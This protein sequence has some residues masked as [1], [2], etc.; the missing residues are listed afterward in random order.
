MMTMLTGT[1]VYVAQLDSIAGWFSLVD[2]LMFNDIL[3]HQL[4]PTYVGAHGDLLEIGCF[5]GKS[6]ILLGYGRG[7][8]SLVVCDIFGDPDL[9][10]CAD[11]HPMFRAA[12]ADR[13]CANW[14]LY[15]PVRPEAFA[16]DSQHLEPR[17]DGR[18][19]RFIHVD[20]CHN[21]RCVQSDITLAVSHAAPGCVIAI[22]DYRATQLPG[23]GAAVWQAVGSGLLFPFAVS[24]AKLYA[25]VSGNE[26]RYWLE[27]LRGRGTTYALPVAHY[28]D[29]EL[30]VLPPG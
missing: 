26:A 29:Y 16:C 7:E 25:C 6:A 19:F 22:D 9:H 17:I 21:Y 12:T 28:P 23:V 3:R 24:D 1:E 11:D 5:M 27:R 10:A 13:F 20:A 4:E 8:D 18:S 30:L 14:D 15:H 2:V